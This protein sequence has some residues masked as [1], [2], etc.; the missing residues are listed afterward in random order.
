MC[1]ASGRRLLRRGLRE[2]MREIHLWSRETYVRARM[3]AEL[4]DEGWGVNHKRVAR[5]IKLAGLEGVSRRRKWHTTKRAKDVRPAADLVERGFRVTAPNRL[6]VA[7]V[8]YVA[9]SSGFLYLAVVMDAWSRRVVGVDGDAPED[10]ARAR[11]AEHGDLAA[12]PRGG[13]PP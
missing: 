7:E 3:Q 12:P 1:A 11:G 8:T 10:G 2:R 6:W 4:R 9:T 5:L 13:D